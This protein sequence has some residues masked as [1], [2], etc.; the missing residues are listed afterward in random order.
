[1]ETGNI[2]FD[3]YISS[4]QWYILLASFNF[5]ISYS[6]SFSNKFFLFPINISY[7]IPIKNC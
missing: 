4:L 3:N 7:K 1:M 5:P 2:L 6:Y